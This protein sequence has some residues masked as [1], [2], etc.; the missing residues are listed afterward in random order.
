MKPE[1]LMGETPTM[2]WRVL[3]LFLIDCLAVLAALLFA[4]PF[5]LILLAPFL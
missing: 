2:R 3:G 4:A 1:M 5:V